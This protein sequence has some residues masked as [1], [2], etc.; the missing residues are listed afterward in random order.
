M[1]HVHYTHFIKDHLYHMLLAVYLHILQNPAKGYLYNKKGKEKKKNG[2]SVFYFL[3]LK[4][5]SQISAFWHN[6]GCLYDDTKLTLLTSLPECQV[7]SLNTT[8]TLCT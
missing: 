4:L 7:D 6:F 2:T 5:A 1:T 3:L 8:C